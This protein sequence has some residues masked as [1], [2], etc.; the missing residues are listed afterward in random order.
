MN[1][2]ERDDKMQKEIRDRV[3]APGFYGRF[4]VEGRYV[5]IDKG[6]LSKTLQKRYAVDT[7][8]QGQDGRA[9]CIEEKIVRWPGYSYTAYALETDSCTKPGHESP[10]WMEYGQADFLL[11]CFTQP[12]ND[13]EAH[14]IDF[15]KLREWFWPRVEMFNVF[16][17]E[18]TINETRGRIVPISAVKDAVPTKRF[19]VF[20]PPDFRKSA[21]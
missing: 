16:Q 5:F 21:A 1:D 2:F 7:I 18:N 8:A 14:L 15:P 13:I 9:V 10:G 19:T 4:S 12:T 3:L 11:Y 17:M 20:A 6:S